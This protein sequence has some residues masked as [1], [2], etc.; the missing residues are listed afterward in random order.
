MFVFDNRLEKTLKNLKINKKMLIKQLNTS[1]DKMIIW[2][3]LFHIH[4]YILIFFVDDCE[5]KLQYFSYILAVSFI[6][7]RSRE[8]HWP[9]ASHWQT[10]SHNAILSTPHHERDSNSQHW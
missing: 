8:N 1:N 10:L 4:F 9:A 3:N 7:G 5:F 6:G 2:L